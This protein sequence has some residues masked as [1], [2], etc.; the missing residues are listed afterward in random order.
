M[1]KKI[2]LLAVCAVMAGIFCGCLQNHG[3]IGR[4]FGSWVLCEMTVNGEDYDS[5]QY[6]DLFWSFQ[7]NIIMMTTVFDHGT[8]NRAFGTWTES[9][10]DLILNLGHKYDGIAQP[11]TGA[12]GPPSWLGLPGSDNVV[13]HYQ[14]KEKNKMSFDYTSPDGTRY[15]YAFKRTH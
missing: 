6:G 11:G 5:S 13:L 12:Y 8:A 3:Y 10:D 1:M 14:V 9:D 2:K 4:L 7:S 15:F